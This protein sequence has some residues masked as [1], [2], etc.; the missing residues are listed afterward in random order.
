MEKSEVSTATV[1]PQLKTTEDIEDGLPPADVESTEK[2]D[3]P[4]SV[5]SR[6]RQWNTRVESLSGFEQGGIKRIPLGQRQAPSVLAYIQMFL[7]WLSAN[8]SINNLAVG[9]LGP[10]LFELGFTDASLC[11][12]FGAALGA[13]S[14]A[15]MSIWGPQSG[16]RTMVNTILLFIA[17]KIEKALKIK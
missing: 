14:T 16:C 7:L 3:S 12:V 17:F 1:S 5:G 15:Y 9:F 10:L 11:A 13:V 8:V 2:F 4:M 6:L